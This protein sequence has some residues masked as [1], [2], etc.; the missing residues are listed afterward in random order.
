MTT[1]LKTEMRAHVVGPCDEAEKAELRELLKGMGE[2]TDPAD[3]W[4]HNHDLYQNVDY[5]K[6][7]GSWGITAE[8]P[9]ISFP[10]FKAKYLQ[11]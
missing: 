6:E 3:E 8:A 11:P 4:I 5:L 7:W 2:N 1:E 9:T 10:D